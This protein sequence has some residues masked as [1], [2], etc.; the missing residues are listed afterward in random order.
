MRYSNKQVPDKQF[1]DIETSQRCLPVVSPG[2]T[3]AIGKLWG[4]CLSGPDTPL[5]IRAL[6]VICLSGV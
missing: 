5:P 3:I 6:I 4:T 2:R 1:H